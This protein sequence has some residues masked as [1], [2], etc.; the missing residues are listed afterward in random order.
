MAFPVVIKDTRG[1]GLAMVLAWLGLI[2]TAALGAALATMAEPPATAAFHERL[3]VTRAA[4]SAASMAAAL[5]AATPDW[6]DVPAVGLASPFVDG[7]PGARRLVGFAFDLER[8]TWRR[9]CG[10]EAAC[11]D[12]LTAAATDERPWGASNPRWRLIVHQPLADIDLRAGRVCPCYLMAW[13][14]D[15]PH[16]AD[17]DPWHD[18]PLGTAGHGLLLVRGAALGPGGA[19]AEVEAL[20]AQP[21]RRSATTCT[22]SRVQSWRLVGDGVP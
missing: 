17:G 8:E 15:D 11:D 3:R 10:R 18:A 13:V 2:A 16:D 20:V 22:G 4:E 6:R 7:M 9:T 5:L 12:A 19:R 14:A 21:C 1:F